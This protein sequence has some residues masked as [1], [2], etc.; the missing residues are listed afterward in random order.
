MGMHLNFVPIDCY[1]K[2]LNYTFNLNH[3][4]I[5]ECKFEELQLFLHHCDIKWYSLKCHDYT[6]LVFTAS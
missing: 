6:A 5:L 3:F 2:R 1:G 4:V